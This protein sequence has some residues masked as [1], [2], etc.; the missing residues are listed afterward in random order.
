ME[1]ARAFVERLRATSRS[2]VAYLELPGA[3]HS[4]DMTDGARTAPAVTVIGLF[5]NEMHRIRVRSRAQVVI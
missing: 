5:L 3:H 4:F 1:H 2:S